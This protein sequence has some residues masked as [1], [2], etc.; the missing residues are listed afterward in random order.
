MTSIKAS[1]RNFAV[2]NNAN[3]ILSVLKFIIFPLSLLKLYLCQFNVRNHSAIETG[4]FRKTATMAS[5]LGLRCFSS[6]LPKN[7][8][9]LYTHNCEIFYF[10]SLYFN[11]FHVLNEY[12]ISYNT[13]N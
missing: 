3:L 1:G 2:I 7:E 4:R 11:S 10:Y 5:L 6:T 8:D 13:N 12:Y 9:I